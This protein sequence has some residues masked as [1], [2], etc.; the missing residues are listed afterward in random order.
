MAPSFLFPT[1]APKKTSGD[2]V[3]YG[4]YT[5]L[6]GTSTQDPIDNGLY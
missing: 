4:E 6:S 1:M 2:P 5:F 3:I